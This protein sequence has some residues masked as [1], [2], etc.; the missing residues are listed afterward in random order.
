MQ[1]HL[2]DLWIMHISRSVQDFFELHLV[3][4]KF[5]LVEVMRHC[6]NAYCSK[7][8]MYMVICYPRS[9]E[10]GWKNGFIRI[11]FH[12]DPYGPKLPHALAGIRQKGGKNSLE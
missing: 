3:D 12:S 6:E 11:P 8:H 10:V 4:V 2:A 7:M 9:G 1:A 5:L